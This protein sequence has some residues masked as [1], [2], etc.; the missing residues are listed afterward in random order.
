MSNRPDDLRRQLGTLWRTAK[1]GIDAMRDVVVRSSQTGR[2]RVDIA[3]LHNERAQLLQQLGELAMRQMDEHGLDDE[4]EAMHGF[5]EKI[6]DV[7][8]RMRSDTAKATDNAFGAPRGFEPEA[9]ADYGADDA[10]E[11][12]PPPPV[13]KK[14]KAAARKKENGK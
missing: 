3:L 14:K 10:E 12:P 6:K 9:A 8:A 5:Y 11:E 2:L 13:V 4:N 1:F 7:E